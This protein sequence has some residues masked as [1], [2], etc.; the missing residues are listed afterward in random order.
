MCVQDVT[1]YMH[2]L[3]QNTLSQLNIKMLWGE[4]E[5]YEKLTIKF[6]APSLATSALLTQL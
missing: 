2:E 4:L 5:E 6:R 3:P 1:N